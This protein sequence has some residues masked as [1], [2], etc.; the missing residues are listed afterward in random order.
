MARFADIPSNIT[1]IIAD[2]VK[3][4]LE[5]PEKAHL[6]DSSPVGVPGPVTTLLLTTIG[7]K[8]GEERHVPLLYVENGG[9]FVVLGSKGGNPK[10]PAWFL[11]LQ[12]HPA[13]EI[14][15]GK[16]RSKAWAR[17]L[18]GEERERIWQK[19][20]AKH[21]VYEK[22]QTRAPRQIPVVAL[23]PVED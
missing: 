4:Y 3:L 5:D 15:V 6:W 2:H 7:R 1:Q 11:N 21:P 20:I 18:A 13:C 9:S 17:I 16:F 10:D 23:D 14:R 19:V 8:S 12:D 22:Y